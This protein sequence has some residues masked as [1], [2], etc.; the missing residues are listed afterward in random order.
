MSAKR[1]LPQVLSSADVSTAQAFRYISVKTKI[2][3]ML[4]VRYLA[5]RLEWAK[6][7]L[8]DMEGDSLVK[9]GDILIHLDEK[10][11]YAA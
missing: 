9:Q 7:R 10:W 2:L 4:T 11:F 1:T 8:E 6:N 3:P 5:L